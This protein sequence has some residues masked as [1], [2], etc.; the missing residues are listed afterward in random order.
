MLIVTPICQYCCEVSLQTFDAC[1]W[2]WL[3]VSALAD[4][5]L[6]VLRGWDSVRWTIA[7]TR[8]FFTPDEDRKMQWQPQDAERV[9]VQLSISSTLCFTLIRQCT[10]CGRSCYGPMHFPGLLLIYCLVLHLHNKIMVTNLLCSFEATTART[11]NCF[12]SVQLWIGSRK[13]ERRYYEIF[14]GSASALLLRAMHK[15]DIAEPDS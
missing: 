7:S 5:P 10:G 12:K 3:L 1:K 9:R 11:A 14:I 4:S 8:K 2:P 6:R 15:S 13:F